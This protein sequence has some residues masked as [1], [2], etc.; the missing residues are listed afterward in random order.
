MAYQFDILYDKIASESSPGYTSREK[1]VFLTKAQTIFVDGYYSKEHSGR[2]AR[3]LDNIKVTAKL[4]TQSATQDEGKPFGT[5]YDLPS[6]FL[7]SMSEEVTVTSSNECLDG[8][9][10]RVIPKREDEYAI[11]ILNP[12]KRPSL[13]GSAGDLAW[14][15]TFRSYPNP[16]VLGAVGDNLIKRVD[17]ITDGTFDINEYYLTYIKVPNDIIPVT[18]G[19]NSTTSQSNCELNPSSHD[20]IVEIA[21][22]IATGVTNPQEYQIKLNEEKLNN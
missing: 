2:R 16:S 3:D 17:L 14:S 6:D 19:D 5:R 12:F 11:Q 1:G 10:I 21:V 13:K 9:R 8:R 22:R 20:E 4:T 7:Y 18:A 15:M